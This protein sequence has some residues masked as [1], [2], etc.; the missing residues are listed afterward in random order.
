MFDVIRDIFQH[1][2]RYVRYN[3]GFITTIIVGVLLLKFAYLLVP[4]ILF[5]GY[6]VSVLY[7]TA[8]GRELRPSFN[9][10]HIILNNGIK[11]VFI[12]FV[13]LLAPLTIGNLILGTFFGFPTAEIVAQILAIEHVGASA[14]ELETAIRATGY[15]ELTYILVILFVLLYSFPAGLTRFAISDS[16]TVRSGFDFETVLPFMLS[17]EYASAWLISSSFLTIGLPLVLLPDFVPTVSTQPFWI[18]TG[19]VAGLILLLPAYAIFFLL[20]L[21][22]YAGFGH[23]WYIYEKRSNYNTNRKHHIRLNHRLTEWALPI[24]QTFSANWRSLPKDAFKYPISG[25]SSVQT[26]LIGGFIVILGYM[27]VSM[28]LI[29]GY[30][31]RVFDQTIIDVYQ[32]QIRDT[33][34]S[35]TLRSSYDLPRTSSMAPKFANWLQ[36]VR[37]GTAVVG[38]WAVL[39]FVPM[40][41]IVFGYL[42]TASS[43]PTASPILQIFFIGCGTF[44]G[45]FVIGLAT[46]IFALSIVPLVFIFVF[47]II[48]FGISLPV[49]A[50][51][52]M[53][54]F[55]LVFT[56]ILSPLAVYLYPAAIALYIVHG[57]P[58]AAFERD[59]LRSIVATRQY[60]TG[61]L[62][63]LGIALIGWIPL[64]IWLMLSSGFVDVAEPAFLGDVFPEAPGFDT[65]L[66]FLILPTYSIITPQSL[67]VYTTLFAS[68][69]TFF[70]TQVAAFSLLGQTLRD[71]LSDEI[72]AGEGLYTDCQ[73]SMEPSAKIK[74]IGSRR[75]MWIAQSGLAGLIGGVGWAFAGILE[76]PQYLLPEIQDTISLI[77]WGVLA[78]PYLVLKPLWPVFF[79]L[80]LMAVL[81]TY[82]DQVTELTLLASA[83]IHLLGYALLLEV[84]ISSMWLWLYP[85]YYIDVINFF[86]YLHIPLSEVYEDWVLIHIIGLLLLCLGAFTLGISYWTEDTVHRLIPL[87][88][89]L[90][91]VLPVMDLLLDMFG[92]SI[93]TGSL[94]LSFV[95]FGAA[96]AWIGHTRWKRTRHG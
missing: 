10:W 4:L 92:L 63:A 53:L 55:S 89:I 32:N 25:I 67:L 41:A 33:R 22:S 11:A 7:Y 54:I 48:V 85:V 59:A 87:L 77:V 90:T 72:S 26:L 64:A 50:A 88:L 44:L 20:I 31:V 18:Y 45:V 14:E 43:M 13:Y 51:Y 23:A 81:G 49:S 83:A 16:N 29:G 86:E 38:I 42:L 61:W 60:V 21:A 3:D 57:Q 79:L 12:G 96:W 69:I 27:V 66:S 5:L 35:T 70:Y 15:Y 56:V 17:K 9:N 80:L 6:L 39:A 40:V 75:D 84:V 94:P 19:N 74:N 37:D 73:Q 58:R 68:G 65:V 95:P 78:F 82:R 76:L 34:Q 91:A 52:V 30:L 62:L 24:E 28:V 71:L 46:P 8:T 1:D 36:I 93:F 47:V 2:L